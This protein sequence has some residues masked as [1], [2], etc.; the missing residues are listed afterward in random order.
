MTPGAP[1]DNDNVTQSEIVLNT[2][3]NNWAGASQRQTR[4]G[5]AKHETVNDDKSDNKFFRVASPDQA[6]ADH[7][8]SELPRDPAN[9]RGQGL[10][11]PEPEPRSG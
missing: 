3:T 11:V 9:N 2:L 6:P 5:N 7:G 4:P 10:G 8:C 1:H